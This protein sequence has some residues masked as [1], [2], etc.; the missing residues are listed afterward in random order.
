M[1]TTPE[2]AIIV[3]DTPTADNHN[4]KSASRQRLFAEWAAL[5]EPT[6]DA[7]NESGLDQDDADQ[8]ESAT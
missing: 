4:N 5:A 1:T 3:V 7:D 6:S 2:A 8:E